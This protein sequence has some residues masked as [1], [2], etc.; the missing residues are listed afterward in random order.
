MSVALGKGEVK[1]KTNEGT[2]VGGLFP[3][4]DLEADYAV[5][6]FVTSHR[7][8]R[9]DLKLSW[10][11]ISMKSETLPTPQKWGSNGWQPETTL[12]GRL[13]RLPNSVRGGVSRL[14]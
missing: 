1:G 3:L 12:P 14:H 13:A 4:L 5:C 11:H 6:H 7:A 10:M 9:Y 8:V 2:W